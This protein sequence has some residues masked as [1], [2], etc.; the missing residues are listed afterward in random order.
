MGNSGA[1]EKAGGYAAG[2][3]PAIALARNKIEM[4]K[5]ESPI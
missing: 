5:Q 2:A 3:K 1:Q 4:L